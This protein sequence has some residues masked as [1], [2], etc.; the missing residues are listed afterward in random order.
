MLH[1]VRWAAR[2][3]STAAT[4]CVFRRFRA[5]RY[6]GRAYCVLVHTA[7]GTLHIVHWA[8]HIVYTAHC[9]LHTVMV[10][11]RGSSSMENTA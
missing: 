9:M 2:G 7:H 11:S 3:S 1:T 4:G 6:T 8:L 10:G 5:D